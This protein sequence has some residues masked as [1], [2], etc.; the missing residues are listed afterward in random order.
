MSTGVGLPVWFSWEGNSEGDTYR[1]QV[2]N[3]ASFSPPFV[4]DTSNLV[5][6]DITLSGL[7]GNTQ[8]WWR[9][10]EKNAVGEGLWSEAQTFNTSSVIL[11]SWLT[12]NTHPKLSW[13]PPA[14]IT[15]PYKV[16]R[17]FCGCEEGDCAGV[18]SLRTTTNNLTYTDLS[19]VVQGKFDECMSVAFYY[20]KGTLTGT[21][22]LSGPSNKVQVNNN[23]I[24]WKA[25]IAEV[26]PELP[27]ETR[28]APNY[29]NPF[30]PVTVISYALA[31]DLHVTLKV[32]DVLGRE[33]VTLVD[34]FQNAGY[35]SVQFSAM[36]GSASGGD[37]ST[38]PSGVYFCKFT[39]ATLTEVRKILLAK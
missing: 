27:T 24:A 23:N 22:T 13:I 26:V 28:L 1:L 21:S 9:V 25:G 16:Y 32:Y 17:Y 39:A 12:E 37:A 18:G 29:P 2:D 4:A 15:S 20:V 33:V 6:T 31:E 3:H 35:N 34:G 10:L 11:L 19:V 5:N 14:G 36:G 38:L 7:A 8:Y 30:N